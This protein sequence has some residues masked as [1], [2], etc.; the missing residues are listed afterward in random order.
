[1][2]VASRSN[3]QARGNAL[4]YPLR[5]GAH[6][7]ACSAAWPCTYPCTYPCTNPRIDQYNP[8]TAHAS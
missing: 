4:R 7:P 3:L 5:M 8:V 2:E 6:A 1:M